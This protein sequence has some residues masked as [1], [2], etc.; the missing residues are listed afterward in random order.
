MSYRN[1]MFEMD[2]NEM[3]D[4]R[5]TRDLESLWRDQEAR[6][7]SSRSAFNPQGDS[8]MDFDESDSFAWV[9]GAGA[10]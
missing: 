10:E 5:S 1:M 2:W 9:L 7:M 3:V 8:T 4:E 6:A